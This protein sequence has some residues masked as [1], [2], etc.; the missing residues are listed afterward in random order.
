M[1]TEA[2]TRIAAVFMALMFLFPFGSNSAATLPLLVPLVLGRAL[3]CEA[4]SVPCL[5]S[6]GY[7]CPTNP[8]YAGTKSVSPTTRTNTATCCYTPGF[9]YSPQ[10]TPSSNAWCSRASSSWGLIPWYK[11]LRFLHCVVNFG[12]VKTAELHIMNITVIPLLSASFVEKSAAVF[13]L[14]F[15][16]P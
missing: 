8:C 1:R 9:S 14:F 16:F 12:G 13:G 3:S 5:S 7:R 6:M 15:F 2:W 10:I 4:H 11:G